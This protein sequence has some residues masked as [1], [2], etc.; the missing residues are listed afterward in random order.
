MAEAATATA[1]G[2]AVIAVRDLLFRWRPDQPPVLDIPALTIQP[3]ERLFIQGPSGS[4]KSTLLNLLGGVMVPER[5][6][7]S[8]R[9]E[10]L[11]ALRGARRDRLRADT[12]GFM[13]QLHNLLPYLSVLE[14]VTLPCHFSRR[15]REQ[16]LAR[17]P[18][19]RD[20]A[21]RLL[22]HLDLDAPELINRP[23]TDLS[24]GQQQRVAAA[25]VLIGAPAIIIAD[26]P[27]S[28][29]DADR[30]GAFLGLL[31]DECD[32]QGITLLLVSHDP[33]LAERF[34]RALHLDDINRAAGTTRED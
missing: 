18:S 15:R 31:A 22:G 6:T 5:G 29:L 32:R 21:L 17:S 2:D 28:A 4:G 11:H 1:T 14:N 13:F 19:L 7:I 23:V 33:A 27:T 26:E 8:L 25:R 10:P 16:A 30:R 12:I 9:G 20:E 34:P 24:V 3:G